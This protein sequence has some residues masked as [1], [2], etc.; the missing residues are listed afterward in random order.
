ML[1][2][3][4]K[5]FAEAGNLFGAFG[6]G[7]AA[8]HLDKRPDARDRSRVLIGDDVGAFAAR[9]ED[10]RVPGVADLGVVAIDEIAGQMKGACV[11]FAKH[12]DPIAD[13]GDEEKQRDRDD[14]IE[15]EGEETE[16][17]VLVDVFKARPK[18]FPFDL[19]AGE[20]VV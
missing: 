9:H 2:T 5:A 1:D 20:F 19:R 10:L 17:R 12:L 18:G 14:P 8:K 15:K 7:D 4:S 3:V 13:L 11:R 16:K 6:D